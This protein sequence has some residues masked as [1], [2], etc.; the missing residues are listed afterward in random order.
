MRLD[1]PDFGEAEDLITTAVGENRQLPIHEAMQP[2][3]SADSF[4]P[5]PDVEMI[6]VAEDDLRAISSS[7][8]RVERL[9]AGLVPTGMNT[10]VSTTPCVVSSRPSRAFVRVSF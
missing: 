7:F 6:S 3:R 2:A 8:A 1:F 5:G 9:H 4:Q 10:G